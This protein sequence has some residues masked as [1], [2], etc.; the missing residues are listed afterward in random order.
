MT[1]SSEANWGS[2][3]CDEKSG[4]LFDHPCKYAAVTN[5]TRCSKSLCDDHFREDEK[6]EPVCITCAKQEL[7]TLGRSQKAR[8]RGYGRHSR[9]DDH[10]P[11]F[12][13]G[14][15]YAG[16]GYYGG[17]YWGNSS[18]LGAMDG[19]PA[20]FTEADSGALNDD[21]ADDDAAEFE[22]DMSES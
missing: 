18:Y 7:H 9:W 2:Q 16:W 1:E 4:F 22:S 20:D 8:K 21:F 12:Y 3:T 6:G 10:D 15:H 11:Y 13:G 5:C 14:Y 17:G 19:D